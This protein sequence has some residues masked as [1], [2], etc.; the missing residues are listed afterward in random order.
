MEDC[1]FTKS[2][3]VSLTVRLYE[4]AF[5]QLWRRL[6]ILFQVV[7]GHKLNFLLRLALVT[8]IITSQS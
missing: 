2:L 5:E 1:T 6:I 3:H 4:V 7:L 8:G